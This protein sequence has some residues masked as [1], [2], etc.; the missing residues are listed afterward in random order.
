MDSKKLFFSSVLEPDFI[1]EG[2]KVVY[3]S[4]SELK[5]RVVAGW[6][7]VVEYLS[8]ILRRGSR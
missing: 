6:G 2:E 1:V 7:E 5:R 3:M 4:D 8:F